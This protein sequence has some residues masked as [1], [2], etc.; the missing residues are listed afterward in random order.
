MQQTTRIY[1]SYVN[2]EN[3]QIFVAATS[4]GLCYVSSKINNEEEAKQHLK[5]WLKSFTL[6]ENQ[7][8]T[9]PYVDELVDYIAEKRQV[10]DSPYDLHGTP[11][12]QSVWKALTEIPY[13]ETASYSEIAEKIGRPKAVRAVGAAIGRNPLL[14]VIPCHRVIGKNGDLTGFRE[15][16]PLKK[17]LLT[18]EKVLEEAT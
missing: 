2:A 13:G 3:W 17:R 8:F 7:E 12:Q 14:I 1:Y 10:F 11:F 6:E 15:G 16:I 4:K 5:K 18:I 9:Q